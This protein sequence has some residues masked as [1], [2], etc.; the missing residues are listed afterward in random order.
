[1]RN[2]NDELQT[3]SW[4]GRG[5]KPQ[6]GAVLGDGEKEWDLE[7]AGLCGLKELLEWSIKPGKII[8]GGDQKVACLELRLG[9][10]CN[11]W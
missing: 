7:M 10:S 5:G 11:Y 2:Y 9:E 6:Q 1:M 3:P 8:G 4:V